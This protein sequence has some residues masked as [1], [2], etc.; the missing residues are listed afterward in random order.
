VSGAVAS[1]CIIYGDSADAGM[2]QEASGQT[3]FVIE[4]VA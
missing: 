4:E 3:Q 2:M 1:N